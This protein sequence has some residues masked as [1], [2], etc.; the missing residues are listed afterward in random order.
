[1]NCLSVFSRNENFRVLYSKS[2]RQQFVIEFSS[3]ILKRDVQPVPLCGPIGYCLCILSSVVVT[4]EVYANPILPNGTQSIVYSNLNVS[5]I[6]SSVLVSTL[7][8]F[9][10]FLNILTRFPRVS[11]PLNKLATVAL[12]V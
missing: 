11:M 5:S 2:G 8:D 7:N 9:Q 12:E 10:A 3:N 1:M 6:P 4:D